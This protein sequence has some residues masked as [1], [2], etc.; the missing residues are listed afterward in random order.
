ML[1]FSHIH[2]KAIKSKKQYKTLLTP[3]GCHSENY[4][5]KN[6]FNSKLFYN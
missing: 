5:N 3:K 6:L 4:L 1:I 2:N